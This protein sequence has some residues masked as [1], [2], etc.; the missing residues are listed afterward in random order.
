VENV[1]KEWNFKNKPSAAQTLGK[2]AM[3]EIQLM[4]GIKDLLNVLVSYL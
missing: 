3:F 2:T 1:Q 4:R